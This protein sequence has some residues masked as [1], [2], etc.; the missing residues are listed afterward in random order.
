MIKRRSLRN[1]IIH[2]LQEHGT[3]V[4]VFQFLQDAGCYDYSYGLRVFRDL[5]LKRII[6]MKLRPDLR[7]S[8][9]EI[10]LGP[11]HADIA[12]PADQPTLG[13]LWTHKTSPS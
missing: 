12:H 8:P 10:H 4:S 1:K 2:H 7:G 6:T 5:E 3:I 9:W 13:D 11:R